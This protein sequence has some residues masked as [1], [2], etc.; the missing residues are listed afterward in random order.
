MGHPSIEYSLHKYVTAKPAKLSC[1]FETHV[2]I[3]GWPVFSCLVRS[4]SESAARAQALERFRTNFIIARQ[5]QDYRR[6]RAKA[7]AGAGLALA[8][9]VVAACAILPMGSNEPWAVQR[10]A[11]AKS[12]QM[13]FAPVTLPD[14]AP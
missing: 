12:E 8:S 10:I 14:I 6:K 7:V 5:L 13:A 9:G 2:R 1:H 3:P 11:P 4:A